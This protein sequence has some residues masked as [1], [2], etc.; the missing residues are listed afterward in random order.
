[1]LDSSDIDADG[2]ASNR[3]EVRLIFGETNQVVIVTQEME[4]ARVFRLIV[5][6]I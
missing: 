2:N 5:G 4:M 1:M 6:I 3:M